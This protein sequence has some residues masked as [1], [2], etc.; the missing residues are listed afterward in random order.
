M[1]K[2]WPKPNASKM[3]RAEALVGKD[4]FEAALAT[5]AVDEWIAIGVGVQG[6]IK[7]TTIPK[8]I[9]RTQVISYS[10]GSKA[11]FA[12]LMKRALATE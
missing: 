9:T 4:A 5:D 7:A 8:L 1:K 11:G 10:G 12:K 2:T 6:Y 3:K